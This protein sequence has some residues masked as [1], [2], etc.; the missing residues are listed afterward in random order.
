[1]QELDFE[2]VHRRG[3]AHKNADSLSRLPCVQCGRTSHGTA[4]EIATAALQGPLVQPSDNL[5]EQQLAD[6]TLGPLIRGKESGN[7]PTLGSFESPTSTNT[8]RLLQIWDQLVVNQGVLCRCSRSSEGPG[9]GLQIVVPE[10]LRTEVLS[11]LHEGL[12][13]ATWAQTRPWD[14]SRSVFTGPDTTRM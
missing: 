14:G 8:R 5:H 6:K 1:M 10:S 4:S 7:K 13:A 2:I 12:R 11:D 9:R 3:S